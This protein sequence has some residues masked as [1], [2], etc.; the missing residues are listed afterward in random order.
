MRRLDRLGVQRCDDSTAYGDRMR[1]PRALAV[2]ALTLVLTSPSLSACADDGTPTGGAVGDASDPGETDGSSDTASATGQTDPD[3]TGTGRK[4]RLPVPRLVVTEVADGL[5]LPWDVQPIG[6]GRLLVTERDRERLTLVETDGATR[7]IP[8]TGQRIW[9]QG[10]TGLMGLEI[11]PAFADNRRI[12]T[13]QGW[14]KP[15]GGHD[16]RVIA[17]QLDEGL[18]RATRARTLLT[19][20]PSTSGRHGGCRLLI[21]LG[22]ALLVGTGDAATSRNPQSLRSLGGKTLLLDRTT[23]AP[24]PTNK[25]ADARGKRRYIHT[26]GHRNVQGLAQRADGSLWSVE[27]GSYRDDE[28]NRLRPGANF[29]W[30]PGP[31]YD[32]SVPMTDFSLPGKQYAARWRSGEPTIATSGAT[33]VPTRGWGALNGTLAVG[34]L[35]GER[36]MFVKFDR[37]GRLVLTRAPAALRRYG[38]IRS[39]TRDLDGSLLVTTSNGGGDTG[40]DLV[41]RIRPE[42]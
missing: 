25:W 40:G 33:F 28:V 12:Y 22:G 32:E 5:D 23:G 27:H 13:C 29:G 17:W 39:V 35:A 6:G 24:W 38:R 7:A 30:D 21:T 15:G 26:F 2:T 37:R 1:L 4:G 34:A 31:G 20:L 3:D 16:I 41:L 8:L 18:T 9:H 36:V 10:E 11:D 14:S 42:R 19:G